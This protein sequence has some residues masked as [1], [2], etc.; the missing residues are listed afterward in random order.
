M[1]D[2]LGQLRD[3]PEIQVKGSNTRKG[4]GGT[5]NSFMALLT[6]CPDWHRPVSWNI[7]PIPFSCLF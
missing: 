5:G 1:E 4:V 3:S 6:A 7:L 2:G